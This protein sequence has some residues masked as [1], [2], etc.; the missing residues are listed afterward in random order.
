MGDFNAISSPTEQRGGAPIDRHKC[1]A[2][3]NWINN[4]NLMDLGVFGSRFTWRGPGWDGRYHV[5][6]Y[7][8]RALC[9]ADWNICFHVAVVK[10]FPRVNSDNHPIYI[11]LSDVSTPRV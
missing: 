2:F 10:T 4:Y 5:F 7:L 6:R 3:H 8:N 1:L 9:N 11:S